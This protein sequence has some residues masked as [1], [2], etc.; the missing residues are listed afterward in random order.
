MDGVDYAGI[1]DLA[2]ERVLERIMELAS[3][4][5]QQGDALND[6]GF[7]SWLPTNDDHDNE[8]FGAYESY[9]NFLHDAVKK[10]EIPLHVHIS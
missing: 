8:V 2:R 3:D 5:M 6:T 9:L 7:L 10:V 1:C 4:R